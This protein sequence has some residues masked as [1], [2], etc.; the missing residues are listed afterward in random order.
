MAERT[1]VV[2][3]PHMVEEAA[4][5][6]WKLGLVDS[7]NSVDAFIAAEQAMVSGIEASGTAKAELEDSFTLRFGARRRDLA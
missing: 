5:E 1:A 7:S 2:V 3:T 4:L 6:M